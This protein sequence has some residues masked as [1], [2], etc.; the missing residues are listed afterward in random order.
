[1]HLQDGLLNVLVETQTRQHAMKLS[2]VRSLRNYIR[3]IITE[4]TDDIVD[5]GMRLRISLAKK[6]RNISDILTD[7]RG[8]LNVITVIQDG[9]TE[10][11]PENKIMINLIVRF[12]DDEKMDLEGLVAEIMTLHEID[13]L[14]IITYDGEK[15]V[16][17]KKRNKIAIEPQLDH[18]VE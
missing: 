4:S 16:E 17:D 3:A 1:M 5:V 8:M 14:R 13:M 7:I 10:P 12:E 18:D 9:P 2:E 11:A 15:Y 6:Q